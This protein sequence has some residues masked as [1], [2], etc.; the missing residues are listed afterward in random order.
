MG[1]LNELEG[2]KYRPVFDLIKNDEEYDKKRR[3][4]TAEETF[5]LFHRRFL[6]MCE[7]LTPL[8]EKLG[9]NIVI[10]SI[11]FNHG[12]QEYITIV[13][14]YIRDGKQYILSI[15]N[16]E[17]ELYDIITSDDTIDTNIFLLNNKKIFTNIFKGIDVYSLYDPIIIKSTSKKF[18]IIDNC[19][20]FTIGDSDSKLFSVS[21]KHSIY[22]QEKK[23]YDYSKINC[24][25]PKLNEL[26]RDSNCAFAIYKHLHVYEEDAVNTLSKKLIY[27]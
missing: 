24:N 10:L 5:A 3:C 1:I 23:L 15:T 6:K 17:F 22:E 19:D 4:L 25:F 8:K 16:L 26:L 7:L 14:K 13:I 18:A 2:I 12:M 20:A 9:K 21:S 11:D 27:H